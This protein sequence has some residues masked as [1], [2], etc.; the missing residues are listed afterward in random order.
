MGMAGEVNRKMKDRSEKVN[1]HVSE[2]KNGSRMAMRGAGCGVRCMGCRPWGGAQGGRAQVR[3][4]R[5]RGVVGR[6]V[7]AVGGVC[8]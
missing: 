3:G 1:G 4:H 7:E 8:A 2:T 5:A 6:R